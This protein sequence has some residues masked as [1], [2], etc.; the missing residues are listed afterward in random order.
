MPQSTQ[1]ELEQSIDLYFKS[2][3]SKR[4]MLAGLL[5][6]IGSIG[7]ALVVYALTQSAVFGIVAF[8]LAG[9]PL[10][11]ITLL[12]LIPP[13]KSITQSKALILAAAQDKSRIVSVENKHITVLEESGEPHLLK[14]V[15]M[16]AWESVIVPYFLKTGFEPKK[17]KAKSER[18]YTVS[19][20]RYIEEQKKRM[21][22]QEKSL[23]D[24]QK[25]IAKDKMRIEAERDELKKRDSQLNEAEEIVINRLSEVETVQAELEQLREDLD[26]KADAIARNSADENDST[27]GDRESILKAKENELEMLKK[28]LLEEQEILQSQ[29]TDL[30]QLK[31]E[32]LKASDSETG[33]ATSAGTDGEELKLLERLH[34]LEEENR[35]LTERSKYVEQAEN[36]LIERI[37]QLTEREANIVQN[38]I[39]G[40]LRSD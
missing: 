5:L 37:D 26:H 8:G 24:E 35:K 9:M 18:K 21:L 32:L 28:Q 33:G 40:G 29:K 22:E 1:Q 31:G 3:S 7:A 19:E 14:G 6:G 30:N 11:Y 27:L 23:A 39:N 17:P 15:E 13:A 38:E 12:V 34:Y 10:A 2:Y 36:A 25:R 4:V 20:R 16:K